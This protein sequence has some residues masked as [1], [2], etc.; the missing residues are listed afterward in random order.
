MTIEIGLFR[1]I[2]HKCKNP[3]GCTVT[4]KPNAVRAYLNQTAVFLCLECG[5]KAMTDQSLESMGLGKK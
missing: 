3:C 1:N 2:C 4:H 5:E